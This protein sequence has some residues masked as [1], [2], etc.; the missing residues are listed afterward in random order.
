[1]QGVV[2]SA[3]AAAA[4]QQQ[5]LGSK[6]Q[7][8]YADVIKVEPALAREAAPISVVLQVPQQ[9]QPPQ[10]PSP[11]ASKENECAQQQLHAVPPAQQLPRSAFRSC[12]QG[13]VAGAKVGGSEGGLQKEECREA[14][15]SPSHVLLKECR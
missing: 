4:Q 15:L 3:A 1:M 13:L 11:T 10:S 5:Q 7:Q 9:P 14:L 6:E 8:P 12:C 2:E